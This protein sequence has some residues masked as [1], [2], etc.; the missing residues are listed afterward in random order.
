MATVDDTPVQWVCDI[1]KRYIAQGDEVQI[2]LVQES[3]ERD[4]TEK[5]ISQWIGDD[6]QP[7]ILRICLVITDVMQS[8]NLNLQIS[9]LIWAVRLI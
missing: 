5:Q 1:A 3:S 2:S 6:F 9:P 7:I 8:L 4:I